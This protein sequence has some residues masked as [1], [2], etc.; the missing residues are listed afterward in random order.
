MNEE[1]DQD[2]RT[3]DAVASEVATMR[4]KNFAGITG[5]QPRKNV[6][7]IREFGMRVAKGVAI[8]VPIMNNL[9]IVFSTKA[10]DI[11][12]VGGLIISIIRHVGNTIPDNIHEQYR[13]A[14]GVANP[15][16]PKPRRIGCRMRRK[17]G[18]LSPSSVPITCRERLR[19]ILE[20]N[21]IDA[22]PTGTPTIGWP[23]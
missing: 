18:A 3:E 2:L 7:K 12:T 21:A 10:T 4:L 11:V 14:S 9:T 16:L 19:G 13:F 20:L 15:R 17:P 1:R 22:G 6:K 8:S 5:N 23:A